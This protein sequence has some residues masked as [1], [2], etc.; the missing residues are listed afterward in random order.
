MPLRES[1][2]H[3]RHTRVYEQSATITT[4]EV[5]PKVYLTA[6]TETIKSQMLLKHPR[7]G[8]RC[9]GG[10]GGQVT[11]SQNVLPSARP[12]TVALQPPAFP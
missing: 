5:L 11:G 8:R 9:G 6:L 3:T 4:G 2:P 12:A 10:E 7:G 1:L